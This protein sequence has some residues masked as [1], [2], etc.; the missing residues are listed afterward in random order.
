MKNKNKKVIFYLVLFFGIGF[1]GFGECVFASAAI[2]INK[3]QVSG[4]TGKSTQEFVELYNSGSSTIDLKTLPLKFHLVSSTG[5]DTS[6]TLSFKNLVIP[7]KGYFLITSEDYV[8]NLDNTVSP[9]AT[10]STSSNSLVS[11]GACYISTSSTENISVID[12]VG[13]GKNVLFEDKSVPNPSGNQIIARTD[14]QDTGNNSNDFNFSD[15]STPHNSLFAV[16]D[17]ILEPDL[18]P[19]IDPESP[20]EGIK[21]A[22]KDSDVKLNEIYPHT[23]DEKDEF[24]ELINNGA[25]CVDISGWAIKDSTNTSSHKT[26][27]SEK[28]ILKSG[29]YFYV[30]K[31]LYLNNGDDI[32]YL[33]DKTGLE[34]D[35]RS[36]EKAIR[37]RSYGFDGKVWRW[38]SSPNEG[39]KNVFN[40]QP[41]FKVIKDDVV[42]KN[43]PANFDVNI[44]KYKKSKYKIT[45][46][47]GDGHKSY[48][49]A[50]THKYEKNKKYSGSV[51]IFNGSEEVIKT[52]KVEVKSFPKYDVE[53]IGLE[54][55]PEGMD[56][57][58]ENIIV[59]NNSKKKVDLQN[60]SIATGDKK[61]TNHPIAPSTILKPK[62]TLKITRDLSKFT[63]NNE[64]ANVEL[65]YPTGKV[66][67][68]MAYDKKTETIAEG[69]I[70]EKTKL[71][72]TWKNTAPSANISQPADALQETSLLAAAPEIEQNL[73]TPQI[74]GESDP[75]AS[76]AEEV[77]RAGTPDKP[78]NGEMF[79]GGQSVMKNKKDFRVVLA[80]FVYISPA[81]QFTESI[82]QTRIKPPFDL[83]SLFL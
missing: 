26:T 23:V 60:W 63:L 51:K 70:L 32:V 1:F 71:G 6:K 3:I 36:Y 47:F 2:V 24:V 61:L 11:D 67:S 52:F 8:K 78:I 16:S 55:N 35:K 13:F 4:G 72:W 43:F 42:Y 56:N 76:S 17:P 20:A 57:L 69:E 18:E 30:K 5:N 27:F 19:E 68:K 81:E 15:I 40:D 62:E 66:A 58:G 82:N 28:T 34:K 64:K 31:N 48:K 14:F 33:L 49:K 53:I 73:E 74:L 59:R 77:L 79:E 50:T 44:K 29:E 45:W 41:N 75:P 39:A 9:D 46:N 10:Y 12:L 83:A 21:C 37:D 65:R 38:T 7:A 22:G 54:A 25:D 80:S